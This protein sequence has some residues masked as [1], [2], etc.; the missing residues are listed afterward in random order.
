MS[1]LRKKLIFIFLIIVIVSTGF[2]MSKVTGVDADA[3]NDAPLTT[4]ENESTGQ[5]QDYNAF[6]DSGSMYWSLVKLLGVLAVVIGL[7]YGFIVLLRKMMGQRVTGGRN[8]K[9]LEV[10][11]T[12]YIGQKKSISLVRFSDRAVL[13]GAGDDNLSVLAELSQEETAKLIEQTRTEK[14]SIGFKGVFSEARK[15]IMTFQQNGLVKQ[16]EAGNANPS[17]AA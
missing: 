12:A 14:T 2:V 13:I 16:V 4:Q 11:E 1:K 5:N 15:K 17:E 9:L 8:G 10:L 6:G 3:G 7:I